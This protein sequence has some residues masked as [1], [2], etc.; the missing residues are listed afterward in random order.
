[1]KSHLVRVMVASSFVLSLVT[2]G[3]ISLTPAN[4]AAA[5]TICK[6]STY[7][8]PSTVGAGGIIG[9][10]WA[11]AGPME[12]G[13]WDEDASS[14]SVNFKIVTNVEE[15]S[16]TGVYIFGVNESGSSF[17]SVAGWDIYL[18]AC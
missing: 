9:Y 12:S 4:V 2:V 14:S 18:Y 13:V 16:S 5:Q 17:S 6:E 1:M 3:T 8:G 15:N 10:T 11:Y 7:V